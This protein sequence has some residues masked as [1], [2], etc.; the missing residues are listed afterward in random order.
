MKSFFFNWG[1]V[2]FLVG[3]IF[4]ISSFPTFAPAPSGLDKVYHFLEYAFLGF[5]T[6][7]GILLSGDFSR[8][9]GTFLGALVALFLGVLDEFHQAFVPARQA[10]VGDALA[11]SLGAIFGAV[12]YTYLGV[13]LFKSKVL[14]KAESSPCDGCPGSQ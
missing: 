9:W 3:F 5:L 8:G 12:F 13:L 10:S 1:P 6:T 4:I 2:L 11:D 7:R 14:Y